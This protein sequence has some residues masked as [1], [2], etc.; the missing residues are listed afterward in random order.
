MGKNMLGDRRTSSEEK[1]S[2]RLL[3]VAQQQDMD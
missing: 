2:T 1:M 3:T